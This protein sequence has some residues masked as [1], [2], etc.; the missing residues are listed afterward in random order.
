MGY[1][2]RGPGKL[3]SLRARA[4]AGTSL[5]CYARFRRLRRGTGRTALYRLLG[6]QRELNVVVGFCVFAAVF[7]R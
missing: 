7:T 4:S 3:S 6:G 5:N 1:L 2:Q